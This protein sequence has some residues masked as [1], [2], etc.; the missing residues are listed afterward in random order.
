[1]TYSMG[2]MPKFINTKKLAFATLLGMVVFLTSVVAVLSI[3]NQEARAQVGASNCLRVASSNNMEGY[4]PY[5]RAPANKN[6]WVLVWI[7]SNGSILCGE[8]IDEASDKMVALTRWGIFNQQSRNYNPPS[9][10][11]RYD[12]WQEPDSENDVGY[13][14]FWEYLGDANRARQNSDASAH[15]KDNLRVDIREEG[16]WTRNIAVD[17]PLSIIRE[18]RE[19]Q[20]DPEPVIGGASPR[21]PRG[22][23]VDQSLDG[24]EPCRSE[25]FFG[26]LTCAAVNFISDMIETIEEK[27]IIPFL[28][29]SPL[30]SGSENTAYAVWANFRNIANALLIVAFFVIIFGQSLSLNLDAYTVKRMVP[31]LVAAALFIQFSWWIVAISVDITNVIGHGLGSIVTAPLDDRDALINLARGAGGTSDLAIAALLGTLAVSAFTGG[32][33][34]ILMPLVLA[35]LGVLFTLVFRQI[36]IIMLAVLS[37]IAFVAWI[38]PN[39]EKAFKMWWSYLLRA[40]L[41]FPLIV[42]LFAAGE[43]VAVVASDAVGGSGGDG[44][45]ELMA[46]IAII[47]PLLLVPATFKFSGG[48]LAMS[49]DLAKNARGRIMGGA[50]GKSGVRGKV[51]PMAERRKEESYQRGG[52]RGMLAAPG[53]TTG[54]LANEG[55]RR[56]TGG[57]LGG[58]GA[59]KHAAM[60]GEGV[61]GAEK[62][63]E[64][65]QLN[66]M[67]AAVMITEG[68]KG[69]DRLRKG[70]KN[71]GERDRLDQIWNKA[72]HYSN[73]P[74]YKAA[75]APKQGFLGRATDTREALQK[76]F[77]DSDRGATAWNS[78][79]KEGKDTNPHI[80]TT[81]YH[82]G[83]V[84]H[85]S[86]MQMVQGKNAEEMSKYTD[87]AWEQ[88]NKSLRE[89]GENQENSAFVY[90]VQQMLDNDNI[91]VSTKAEQEMRKL[92]QDHGDK[93]ADHIDRQHIIDNDINR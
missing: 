34:L 10:I 91:D 24:P 44:A 83:E 33:L 92:V 78:F 58:G 15:L 28:E 69:Y 6:N 88:I 47:A 31:R 21:N 66:G 86:L 26:W 9:P 45:Y 63:L 51:Q 23:T 4:D 38:L 77:G 42:L 89:T 17:D 71:D 1:M 19:T 87:K 36:L 13:Y 76:T 39:T 11:L 75:A 5:R 81:D 27:V 60:F 48:L 93:I 61:A 73:I 41:M 43:L 3:S 52:L 12:S 56:G 8:S 53:K 79:A 64:R 74:V 20:G 25:G 54:R 2:F 68:Q 67:E 35:A 50:D 32:I 22:N 37:P 55:L 59:R 84:S 40:L 57:A 18:L 85:G 80:L 29:V 16:S 72:R 7:N 90:K 46:L 30:D 62:E 82:S 49:A 14:L 65:Q 70:A